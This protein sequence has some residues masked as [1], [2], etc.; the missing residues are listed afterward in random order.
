MTPCCKLKQ[1]EFYFYFFPLLPMHTRFRLS[2]LPFDA[3]SL[4]AR[5]ISPPKQQQQQ[6]L[7]FHPHQCFGCRHGLICSVA[8][9]V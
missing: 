5:T 9:F 8:C 3:R 6:P 2:V 7:Q 4:L 1:Q